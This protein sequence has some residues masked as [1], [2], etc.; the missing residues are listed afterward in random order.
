MARKQSRSGIDGLP[1]AYLEER[2]KV[3]LEEGNGQDF[4][5]V[6]GLAIYDVIVLPHLDEYVD[7]ASIDK[8]GMP[9]LLSASL[10][11]MVDDPY[12]PLSVHR[13][14]PNRGS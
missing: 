4:I 9:D 6:L 12:L 13:H 5:N 3:F 10:I 7:L 2:M 11:H 14:S 8:R 1:L